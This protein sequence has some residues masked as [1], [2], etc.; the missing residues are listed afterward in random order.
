MTFTVTFK[1]LLGDFCLCDVFGMTGMIVNDK[2]AMGYDSVIPCN[3]DS[4]VDATASTELSSAAA[5]RL[6]AAGRKC[7]CAA[8]PRIH[9]HRP[10]PVDLA[11]KTVSNNLRTFDALL[12]LSPLALW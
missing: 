12:L 5:L 2:P 6:K 9:V 4:T 11:V 10:C 7:K 3:S 1:R 8:H